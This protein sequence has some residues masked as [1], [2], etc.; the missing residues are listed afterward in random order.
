MQDLNSLRKCQFEKYLPIYKN[1]IFSG[2]FV[3][4]FMLFFQ[5]VICNSCH[6]KLLQETLRQTVITIFINSD[7]ITDT[8]SYY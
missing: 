4:S 5:N 3:G 1:E 8:P 7:H 6:K 2:P